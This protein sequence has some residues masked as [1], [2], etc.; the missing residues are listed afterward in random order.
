[1]KTVGE[2]IKEIRKMKN[3]RQKDFSN[4][5]QASI[6]S[7]ESSKRNVTIDKVQS[8]LDDI[9]MSLREFE[10]IRND[11]CLLPSDELFYDFTSAKNSIDRISGT[12]LIK[13]IDKHLENNPKDFIA[14]SLR[15]IED[16]F[17]KKLANRIPIK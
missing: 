11:Y 17:F 8:F 2:T 4:L 13:K 5:S 1:M 16:V 15:V 6:A 14:Y 9:Q 10:Y 3:L 12:N 7:I